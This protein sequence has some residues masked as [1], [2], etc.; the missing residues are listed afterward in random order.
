MKVAINA[1]AAHGTNHGVGRYVFNLLR[2][3]IEIDDG[4]EYLVLVQSESAKLFA[5]LPGDRVRLVPFDLSG[6]VRGLFEHL[7][8]P[9]WVRKEGV[10]VYFGTTHVLPL[11]KTTRQVVVIHDMSWFKVSQ[12][13][14]SLKRMY[15]Q[16]LIPMALRRADVIVADSDST[17]ADVIEFRSG[18]ENPPVVVAPLGAD[19]RF[20][21]A[22][23]AEIDRVRAKFGVTRPYLLNVGVIEP[24]KNQAGLIRAFR[25]TLL[26]N[27]ELDVELLIVGSQ[28]IGWKND[29]VLALLADPAISDRV[30]LLSDV[31]DAELVAL[32][33]GCEVFVYPSFYEGFG[34][35]ILEAMSCGAPVITSNLSSMPEVGGDAAVYID[36]A[37][38][39]SITTAIT[40][41]LTDRAQR[42][43]RA[44]LG[45]EQARVFSWAKTAALTAQAFADACRPA[46]EA[47]P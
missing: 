9:L 34:L 7:V 5:D 41:L 24:R 12:H 47:R 10:D 46:T 25:E 26:R 4:T 28:A 39:E 44:T 14:S 16:A 29:E 38:D 31:D 20:R 15:F 13:H 42:E 2:G 36:P 35:P 30:R 32:M 40:T 11:L 27:P 22:N 23:D 1:L 45:L 6:A 43:Q 37:D 8:L 3:L 33:T 21:P 18:A 19:A 17:R